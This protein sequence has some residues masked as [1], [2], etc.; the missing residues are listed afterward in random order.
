MKTLAVCLLIGVALFAQSETKK[1][2]FDVVSIKPHKP[3]D[4]RRF[5]STPSGKRFTAYNQ[6][7]LNLIQI[8]YV[9][10]VMPLP[11]FVVEGLPGWAE[12]DRFDVEA[13]PEPGF[14]PTKRQ[15]MEMLQAMLE[16]RFKLK[17]RRE[18]K[19][20]PIYALVIDKGGLKMR[21]SENQSGSRPCPGAGAAPAA[22]LQ[23]FC[24]STSI[25]YLNIRL[26]GEVKRRVVDKTG[27]TGLY[28]MDLQWSDSLTNEAP[29]ASGPSVFTALQ[30]QLG[31]RL[32]SEIGQVDA[33]VAGSVERPSE[34]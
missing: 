34:N 31:L 4:D 8:A 32:V 23:R 16:E 12:R 7:L 1:L 14:V 11:D 26:Y 18:P 15:A 6:T 3:G 29:D 28:D 13:Q 2:T 24:S 25:A 9:D 33:F 22:G 5:Y 10:D 17:I 30:E 27:L 19:N 20:A 21:P